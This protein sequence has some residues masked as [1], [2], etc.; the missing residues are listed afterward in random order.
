MASKK[1]ITLK[2]GQF[3]YIVRYRDPSGK[4]VD[5]RFRRSIDADNRKNEAE[6]DKQRGTWAD[7]RRGRITLTDHIDQWHASRH[8]LRPST[9]ARDGSLIRQQVVPHLGDRRISTLEPAD[10]RVWVADLVEAGY[11][12]ST[13]GKAVQ[14]LR[15]AMDSAVEDGMIPRSPIRGVKIPTRPAV[16]KRYLSHAEITDLT[17]AAPAH[18]RAL[19]LTAAYTGMRFGELAALRAENLNLLRPSITVVESLSE[20]GGHISTGP[21]KTAA[22]RRQVSLPRYLVG[23]LGEHMGA[24]GPGEDNRV[25]TA[26]MDGPLRRTLFRRRVWLPAVDESVGQPC[27]F[28]DLRHSH[29]ALL[30]A[31][32]THPKV[33]QARLG[34]ASIR[35]TLDVYGHLFEGLDESAA[36]ALDATITREGVGF[37]WG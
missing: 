36:D 31:E 30:I 21:P 32:G 8:H 10:I 28:H 23:F 7:P 1:K 34:H 9:R 17:E 2:N 27:R 29:A 18:H 19:I 20:V 14:I 22:S 26:P 24:Y 25:F 33:I 16:E 12:P 5:E 35:T 4:S 13:V 15:A 11:A 6:V 3:S 37:S